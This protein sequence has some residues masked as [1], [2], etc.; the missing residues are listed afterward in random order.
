LSVLH[1]KG[2]HQALPANQASSG[3]DLSM[4]NTLAYSGTDLISAEKSFVTAPWSQCYKI[5]LFLN[6]SKF[7]IS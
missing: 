1:S 6:L 2:R 4:T 5:L 3:G 7:A